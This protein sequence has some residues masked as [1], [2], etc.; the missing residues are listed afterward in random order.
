MAVIKCKMCGGDLI[1]EEGSTVAECEYCGS[2]QTIPTQDNEKK[3][4]LFSRAN[5]LRMNSEF[6]KAFGI[7]ESIVAEFPEEAEAYWG[8]VLCKYGIEYVDDPASGKKIPTCHRSSFDSVMDDKDFEQ[9]LENADGIARRIYREEAKAIE[10]IRKGIIEVSGKE[11]PYDIFI[12]YKETAENGDRTIDSVIA[13]DVYDALTAKGY[14]VFFSRITLED[15][16]G[17]EYEP[18]IFA[19]L[20]SAKIMLAFGTDYEYYNAV[21]V[22]NEWSRYLKLM[23]KDKSKHLIPCY[24]NIDAYD[25]PKEFAKLQ[26]QDL[27]KIGAMQDLLRGIE[28]I[29]PKAAPIQPA[30]APQSAM[31]QREIGNKL[32]NLL[33]RGN[34]ALED[35]NWAKAENFYEDALNNDAHSA[36]G[37]IGLLLSKEKCRTLDAFI[38]KRKEKSEAVSG[39]TLKLVP[40]AAHIEAMA[41]KHAIPGYLEKNTVAALYDFNLSYSSAV[42][43]REQQ[44]AEETAFWQNQ[45]QL[46][47][48]EQYAQGQIAEVIQ[49]AK[50]DL[51]GTMNARIK[52]A[53]QQEANAVEILKKTYADHIRQA[54][55]KA[56][57][58]KQTAENK[59]ESDYQS[60][61]Q[62]AKAETSVAVLKDTAD[63]FA[64][65]GEYKDSV[66]LAKHCTVRAE[67]EQAKLDAAKAAKEKAAA[68]EAAERAKK[69]KMIAGIV[70]VAAVAAIAVFMVVTKV[71]IPNNHYNAAV[72]LMNDGKYE[73]AIAAFGAMEGYR[74]SNEQIANCQIAKKDSDYN[75]AAAL[76]NA[77]KYEEAIAAF[78]AMNGYKDSVDRIDDCTVAI[79][80][81]EYKAAV[82]LMDVKDY[83]AAAT[84]FAKLNGY[85]D[86]EEKITE[87]NYLRA[88]ILTED[89]DYSGAYDIYNTIRDY[90]DV[91]NLLTNDAHLRKEAFGR[92]GS[93]V[94]FGQYEQD[95]DKS[96]GAEDIEWL[97]LTV[98]ENRNE[99]KALLL[100]RYGLD[101]MPYHYENAEF[102]NMTWEKSSLRKW[103]ATSF[104][105]TAFTKKEQAEILT[106]TNY[107]SPYRG[108]GKESAATEDKVFLLSIDEAQEY[109]GVKYWEVDGAKN[110]MAARVAPTPFAVANG[111]RQWDK[112]TTHD[113]KTATWWWLRAPQYNGEYFVMDDG[114]FDAA[115]QGFSKMSVCVRPA[116]WVDLNQFDSP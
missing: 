24:K 16:L 23:A 11:E 44:K 89:G 84:S 92:I 40:D 72:T 63:K 109:L 75:A 104:L 97:I 82:A 46:H 25:M 98:K 87:A 106:T 80:E 13:Q 81:L 88:G 66:N 21:W 94:T 102:E 56:A 111:A 30:M 100:S 39:R 9:A 10:E 2:R 86:S 42:A 70:A 55:G 18:Y 113:S 48:A 78:K 67:E 116:I 96:N 53:Q 17:Q 50:D 74:D 54:D 4:T 36:E 31:A 93:Y 49:R 101:A 114:S 59:R 6:D 65:L 8:L 110:N 79:K 26:A 51:F 108:R 90:K 32:S 103:L 22:K 76:M 71:V 41:E 3:L 37:Y 83:E 28:K 68:K 73:E 1:I 99:H 47:R 38:R 29:L 95:A 69:N 45:P 20:N 7:Y 60:W 52:T 34:I 14:R 85:R 112:S 35:G 19:A 43:N 33:E 64:A 77:G 58:L 57:Q 15:K 107:N 27:G 62:I 5:R 115:G 12:C 91:M 105:P 61:L